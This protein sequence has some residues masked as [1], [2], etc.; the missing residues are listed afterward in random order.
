MPDS[1]N[2]NRQT[3][4]FTFRPNEEAN[5]KPLVEILVEQLADYD[6]SVA[7]SALRFA[8]YGTV[9][10]MSPMMVSLGFSDFDAQGVAGALGDHRNADR[11][12]DI[13]PDDLKSAG[14]TEA[15]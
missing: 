12:L 2:T 13:T 9:E 4:L 8:W 7:G 6:P 5:G 1:A 10:A 14:F 15:A 3:F 11:R